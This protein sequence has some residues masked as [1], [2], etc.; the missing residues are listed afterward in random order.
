MLEHQHQ[1]VRVLFEN[2][3]VL[4]VEPARLAEVLAEGLLVRL[5]PCEESGDASALA[6]LFV[7]D[8]EMVH[9]LAVAAEHVLGVLV[10]VLH[11]RLSLA[12]DAALWVVEAGGDDALQAQGEDIGGAALFVV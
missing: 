11:E 7:L 3:V 5:A 6:R 1:L 10:V 9:Q 12:E 2:L 4:D 8:V